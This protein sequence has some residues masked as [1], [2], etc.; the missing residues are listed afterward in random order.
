MPKRV[1][2]P[3][4]GVVNFPDEMNDGQIT[5]AATRLHLEKVN[6]SPL[7]SPPPLPNAVDFAQNVYRGIGQQERQAAQASMNQA[8]GPESQRPMHPME[9]VA[10]IVQSLGH[11]TA[12]VLSGVYGGLADPAQ[13]AV[14]AA[15]LIDPAI[16]PAYFGAQAATQLPGSVQ[17]AVQEPTPENVQAPLLQG[18]T[19]AGAAG[20]AQAPEAGAAYRATKAVAQA[21]PEAIR[22]TTQEALGAGTRAVQK[23][24]EKIDAYNTAAQADFKG[25]MDT[26]ADKIDM[27]KARSQVDLEKFRA[28]R[29]EVTRQNA[30]ALADHQR[31]V[32]ELQAIND[33]RTQA[34]EAAKAQQAQRVQ[35]VNDI[36][37]NGGTLATEL[38]GL[39]KSARATGGAM[40]NEIEQAVDAKGVKAD[41]PTLSKAVAA[42]RAKLAGSEEKIK[43]FDSI[44][45]ATQ[46]ESVGTSVGSVEPGTSLYNTLV[47]QGAINPASVDF[48]NLKGYYTELG[49]KLATGNLPGDVYSALG[50]V[51]QSIGNEMQRMATEAGVGEKLPPARAYWHRFEKTFHD[52]RPVAQGGSPLARAF[53]AVDPDY[54]VAPF[55]GPA[56]NRA[57][58]MLEQYDPRLAGVA[59]QTIAKANQV[60]AIGTKAIKAPGLKALPEPPTPKPMPSPPTIRPTPNAP[61]APTMKMLDPEQVRR[62]QVERVAD[63]LRGESGWRIWSDVGAIGLATRAMLHGQPA[64]AAGYM[65]FPITRRFAGAAMEAPSFLEWVSRNPQ[66][67]PSWMGAAAMPPVPPSQYIPGT[68]PP[69]R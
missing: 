54:A 17:R 38:K 56:G 30:Q 35:L 14:M 63:Y 55:T 33:M 67:R 3:D 42:G 10:R 24:Q 60:K 20:G 8:I 27:E 40:F 39:E 22:R 15:G 19:I 13:A 9:R 28:D 68:P 47:E 21:A 4:V 51:R 32:K 29:A 7:P 12:G 11:E 62:E 25:K 53:R 48:R 69:T 57:V 31:E 49:E 41:L 52:M 66:P 2:I 5:L 64:A 43:I 23:A 6:Q 46:G 58:N 36:Q 26:F 44:L 45:G 59:R 34:H 61:E 65:A 18:A 16:P 37:V 50:V 1:N